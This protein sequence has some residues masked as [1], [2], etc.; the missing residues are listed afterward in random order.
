MRP[1]IWLC[2]I[3]VSASCTEADDGGTCDGTCVCDGFPGR[4][5]DTGPCSPCNPHGEVQFYVQCPAGL[6]GGGVCQYELTSGD[7]TALALP[8]TIFSVEPPGGYIRAPSVA[9]LPARTVLVTVERLNDGAVGTY[10]FAVQDSC[11]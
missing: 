8:I 2:L 6:A 10:P 9:N 3:F 7:P 5:G 11:Q 1:K 4:P